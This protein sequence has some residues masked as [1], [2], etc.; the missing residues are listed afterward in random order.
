[1]HP[2]G[3]PAGIGVN[4]ACDTRTVDPAT[5]R[6]LVR[7]WSRD[8]AAFAEVLAEH[9]P[10]WRSQVH[11]VAG[12]LLVLSG[13]GMYVNRLIGGG[14]ETPFTGRDLVT[15]VER[16]RAIGV[17]PSVEVTPLIHP[18]SRTVLAAHGFVRDPAADVAALV[19]PLPGEAIAAPEDIVV[20]PVTT[21]DDL[22]VWQET[23]ARG[24]GLTDPAPRRA[25]DAFARAA[26][27][28]DGDGMV[29]AYDARHGAPV[30]SASTTIRDDVATVGA[31]STVPEERRRG[32]QAA[33]LAYRLGRADRLGCALAASTAVV[34]GASER[35]LVRHGFI[36]RF[37]VETHRLR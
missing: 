13:T 28:V 32:V 31:M 3:N 18:T 36:R 15:V 8:A 35:N 33:L 34:G 6:A 22:A 16:S 1:M 29:I 17:T 19:R 11:E 27:A 37:V 10:S 25:A 21:P 9:D 12:G 23:N 20:R 5:D 4:R 7:T 26:F 14:I 24:W 2:G 30:G